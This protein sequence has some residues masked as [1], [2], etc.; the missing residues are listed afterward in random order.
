MQIAV[1]AN[2]GRAPHAE[3]CNDERFLSEICVNK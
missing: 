3:K 1:S 2:A